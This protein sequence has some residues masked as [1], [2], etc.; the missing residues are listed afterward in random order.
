MKKNNDKI[1]DK[2][3]NAVLQ[4]I[5]FA[6]A[7]SINAEVDCIYPESFVIGMLTTG[8]NP[9]TAFLNNLNV[10]LELCLK[11]FKDSLSQR[12]SGN[13]SNYSD[14]KIS[15]QVIQACEDADKIRGEMG[16]NYIGVEHIFISLARISREVKSIIESEN[17][18]IDKITKIL[19]KQSVTKNKS[20]EL[21]HDVPSKSK[22][23]DSILNTYC[24]DITKMAKENKLDPIIARDPE[25]DRAITILCRRHKSNPILLGE[26]GVGKTAVVEGI[27][28]RIVSGTVPK[29]IK[30]HK[31]YSLRLSGLVAGTKY[32]GEFEDRVQSLIEEIEK[33]DNCILFID[34]IHTLVGAGASGGGALDASN[35]LKPFLARGDL[36]CIGATTSSDFKKYFSKDGALSRRFEKVMVE[37]PTHEQVKLILSSVKSKLEE[38]HECIITDDAIDAVIEYTNR[39][40][41]VRYFP[42]KAIDI[43]D[44]ACAKHAWNDDGVRTVRMKDIAQVVSEQSQ[45]PVEAIMWDNNDRLVSIE[46][47]LKKRIIGQDHAVSIVCRSLKNALS[48]VRDPSKPIG[49]FVFGGES[50][51]GKTY[52]AKEL[53]IAVF[54]KESSFI[55]L[56]MSEF[57]EPHSISKLIG[58]P[59]GYVGFRE[60]DVFADKIRRKPYSIVLLDEIEKS[61]PN[62]IKAFLQVMSDGFMTDA[63]GEKVDFRHAIIIMT[64]NFNAHS[65][66]S[67]GMGFNIVDG[68][69]DPKSQKQKLI[70][71]CKNM[72]GAEFVNRVDEF[73]PFLSLTK[74]SLIN[75]ASLQ[76]SDF[77]SR[78]GSKKCNIKFSPSVPKYLA[79][80][81]NEMHGS[82]ATALE[83]LIS[84][85]IS[86]SVADVLMEI[87]DNGL[88]SVI[89]DVHNN[90]IICRKRKR[91]MKNA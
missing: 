6:K 8:A 28:Q 43:L 29:C 39:Y 68:K 4:T 2:F 5:I 26:P 57:S 13:I 91:K 87:K 65:E 75:I 88:Y 70:D 64:G 16:H 55:R 84:Q 60:T 33:S 89:I 51:T 12:K 25:I 85:E 59:P 63:I 3:N 36:K 66:T 18:E 80:K 73:I 44:T 30:D 71:Y 67:S 10:D 48:G 27:A 45:I 62:V 14:L 72:Y 77:I 50:G 17:I 53:S 21:A 22:E 81:I 47:N 79:Q 54:G 52:M 46:N 1:Y 23:I 24:V 58:S 42:D 82:N 41:P 40:L 61:H 7:A 9:V 56:D 37:E 83:R 78:I 31:I 90:E 35:I 20:K 86:S 11:K 74:E 15:K 32:R 49:S 19:F 38:Y 69:Y 34:E 76:I